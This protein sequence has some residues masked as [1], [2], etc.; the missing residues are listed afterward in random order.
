MKSLPAAPRHLC[1][2]DEKNDFDYLTHRWGHKNRAD[3][4][5]H[6]DAIRPKKTDTSRRFEWLFSIEGFLL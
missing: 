5:Q 2:W 1:S 6:Q 3:A 4:C